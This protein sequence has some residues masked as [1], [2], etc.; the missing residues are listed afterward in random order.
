MYF[1]E[2]I[3]LYQKRM[4]SIKFVDNHFP[5]SSKEEG[6]KSVKYNNALPYWFRR[7]LSIKPFMYLLL[8]FNFVSYCLPS[9]RT[10]FKQSLFLFAQ[11][12]VVSSLVEIVYIVVNEEDKIAKSLQRC[13]GRC[14][15][16]FVVLEP[17]EHAVQPNFAK[18]SF[19]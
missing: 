12:C 7:R 4:I 2:I 9:I 17:Y 10:W 14:L 18:H 8:I 13:P 16:A 3:S 6:R 15:S 1:W 5:N 19:F 11:G